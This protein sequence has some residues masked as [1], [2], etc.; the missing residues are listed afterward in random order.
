MTEEHD[1]LSELFSRY[2]AAC[3]DPEPGAG[4]MPELW[5]RIDARRSF[6]WRLRLYA[7]G[8]VT[9]AAAICLAIGIFAS[10]FTTPAN[11]V[12][13]ETYIESLDRAESPESFAYADVIPADFRRE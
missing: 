3:P 5:Q 9:V 7:R 2:R 8:L 13:A 4:F 12:Y 1:G 6:A 10:T 11:P